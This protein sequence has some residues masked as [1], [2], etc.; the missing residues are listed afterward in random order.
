[1]RPV[2]GT[3][4]CVTN[5]DWFTVRVPGGSDEVLVSSA[6]SVEYW[7]FDVASSLVVQVIVTR[8]LSTMLDLIL[9][10]TGAVLSSRLGA[11]TR[12]TQWL[13]ALTDCVGNGVAP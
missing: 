7:I 6:G 3:L 4:C 8:E 11:N 9:V 10:M 12:S 13:A 1:A 5:A 2:S